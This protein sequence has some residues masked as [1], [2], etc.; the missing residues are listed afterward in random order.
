[1]GLKKGDKQVIH[2]IDHNGLNNDDTNLKVVSAKEN[3]YH[4]KKHAKNNKSL[5][6]GVWKYFERWRACI[7]YNG[8]HISLGYFDT[9][10][11]AAK[12]YDAKALE[13]FG[14]FACLNFP[15]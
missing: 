1:M 7:M 10:E 2:H 12:A 8:K 6:K 11:Q 4:R 14:E 5:Y 3:S 13:L 9:Q 15:L